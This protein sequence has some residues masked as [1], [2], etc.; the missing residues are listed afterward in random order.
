MSNVIRHLRNHSHKLV[1]LVAALVI[2]VVI[3]GSLL[4]GFDQLADTAACAV[5][6][7]NT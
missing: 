7:S 1:A 5:L 2:T 6:A 4:A 3:Q